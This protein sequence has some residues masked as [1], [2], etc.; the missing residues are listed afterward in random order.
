ML[1]LENSIN[2]NMFTHGS[3]SARGFC[4]FET[5]GHMQLRTL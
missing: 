4:L 5:K 3:G 2:Y 1:L